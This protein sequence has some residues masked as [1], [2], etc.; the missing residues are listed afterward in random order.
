MISGCGN[1]LGTGRLSDKIGFSSFESRRWISTTLQLDRIRCE[2]PGDV[3]CQRS[4]V[5]GDNTDFLLVTARYSDTQIPGYGTC[6]ERHGFTGW[7]NVSVQFSK[8]KIRGGREV[9][10]LFGVLIRTRVGRSGPAVATVCSGYCGT[11]P[12]T[13]SKFFFQIRMQGN[14]VN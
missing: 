2:S 13:L 12:C 4:C 14:L 6:V 9:L 5:S 1:N 8:R 3:S 7:E 11:A 10:L